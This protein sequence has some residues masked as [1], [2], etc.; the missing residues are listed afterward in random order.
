MRKKEGL[1]PGP[2]GG[3]PR[4]GGP[5]GGGPRGGG[6]RGHRGG[7]RGPHRPCMFGCLIPVLTVAAVIAAAVCLI[8]LVAV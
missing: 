1:M 7:P 3:G 8:V 2:G 4:G 6:P 5:R